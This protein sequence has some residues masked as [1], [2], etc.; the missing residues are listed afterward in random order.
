MNFM[1]AAIFAQ[2]FISVLTNRKRMG[3]NSV[4]YVT[5]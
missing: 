3:G 1:S 2:Q 4:H 5:N